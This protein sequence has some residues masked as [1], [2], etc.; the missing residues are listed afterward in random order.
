MRVEGPPPAVELE[1]VSFAYRGGPPV[2]DDVTLADNAANEA[3]RLTL[4]LSTYFR[5]TGP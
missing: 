1:G 4:Q 5:T 2:L 3:L